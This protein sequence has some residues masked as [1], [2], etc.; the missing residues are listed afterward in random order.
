MT[1]DRVV[2]PREDQLI[3]ELGVVSDSPVG[4]RSGSCSTEYVRG[5][6]ALRPEFTS[7]PLLQIAMFDSF[8]FRGDD[9]WPTV[10]T[11]AGA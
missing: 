10:Q 1:R 3:L 11:R 4:V 8:C 2:S 9:E 6:E 7:R 5:R